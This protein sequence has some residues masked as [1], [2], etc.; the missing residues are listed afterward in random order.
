MSSQGVDE[1]DDGFEEDDLDPDLDAAAEEAEAAAAPK[2]V[3]P[4]PIHRGRRRRAG[5]SMRPVASPA[6]TPAGPQAAPTRPRNAAQEVGTKDIGLIWTG[7]IEKLHLDQRSPAEVWIRVKR[8]DM[9]PNRTAADATSDLPPIDGQA[10]AGTSEISPGQDLLNYVTEVY[11]LSDPRGP[12]K[13]IFDISYKSGQSGR[14][15]APQGELLLGDPRAIIRQRDAAQAVARRRQME[16]QHQGPYVPQG[17]PRWGG[18]SDVGS[19]GGGGH[20][21]YTPGMGAGMFQPPPQAGYQPP[22]VQAPAGA[23]PE[24]LAM[25]QRTNDQMNYLMGQLQQRAQLEGL[26]QFAQPAPVQQ[27]PEQA[28]ATMAQAIVMAMKAVGMGPPPTPVAPVAAPIPPVAP[29]TAEQVR[30]QVGRPSDGL[31]ALAQELRQRKEIEA[32]L[33]DLLGIIPPEEGEDEEP[34]RTPQSI[35]IQDDPFK[36]SEIPVV[37]Q[38][39]GV[40][41]ILYGKQVEGETLSAYA[42]RLAMHNPDAAQK[43]LGGIMSRVSEGALGQVL[44]QMVERGAGAAMGAPMHVNPPGVVDM[45][46]GNVAIPPQPPPMGSQPP[47]K[48][49]IPTG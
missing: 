39:I 19:T 15:P 23:S 44:R 47:R 8:I 2:P 11:H 49:G 35:E 24:M 42:M 33:R 40:G 12:A 30:Q 38:A 37:G 41:K 36:M 45:P 10:V 31:R 5:R 27:S 18:P 16:G 14:F 26:P 48:A 21:S 22:V 25:Y 43:I 32:E 1:P 17:V 46:M 4:T 7:V 20:G 6:A 13:Y 28:A 29:A 9:S 34:V 3:A